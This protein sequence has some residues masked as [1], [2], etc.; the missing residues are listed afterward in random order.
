M[1]DFVMVTGMIIKTIPFGDYDRRI[2]ILTKEKGKISAFAKNARRQNSSL[3]AATNPFS[4]GKFKLYVGR[5]SYNIL[6]AEISNY[7]EGLREDFEG[8]YYG[9]YFLE[10]A[11][12]YTRENN[13]E[14]NFLKLLY[15]S[16]KAISLPQLPNRLIRYIFE[17]K[18]LSVNGEFPG[19]PPE[20][21]WLPASSYA[22]QFIMETEI[23]KL[24]TFA[25]SGEVLEELGKISAGYCRKH[26]DKSF[27]SLEIIDNL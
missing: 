23:E 3:V 26:W 6:E 4:F 8:A 13:D 14:K 1:Q 17:M 25:V 19:I 27:K 21:N 7:F 11:D 20:N 24:Y 18:S 9:M 10:V 5:N 22:V 15:Q 12:Y 2:V 16:V